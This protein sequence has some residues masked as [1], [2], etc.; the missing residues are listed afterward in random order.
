MEKFNARRWA[1]EI[2]ANEG[3]I[4]QQ[5]GW[6]QLQNYVFERCAGLTRNEQYDALARLQDIVF[7]HAPILS[8]EEREKQWERKSD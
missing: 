6:R 1:K 7:D 2:Y 3:S 4:I 8:K 5:M